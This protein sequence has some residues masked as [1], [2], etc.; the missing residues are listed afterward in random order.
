MSSLDFGEREEGVGT[1]IEKKI[2]F[3]RLTEH[4]KYKKSTKRKVIKKIHTNKCYI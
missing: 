1:K 3:D 4:K 2:Y